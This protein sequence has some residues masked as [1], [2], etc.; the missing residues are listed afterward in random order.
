[1]RA[2]PAIT[3]LDLSGRGL[4]KLHLH[5]GAGGV[6]AFPSGD[7]I[8][9]SFTFKE[10]WVIWLPVHILEAVN[11]PIQEKLFLNY[12]QAC[13]TSK[14]WCDNSPSVS[15]FDLMKPSDLR[16]LFLVLE[17]DDILDISPG[18]SGR[19]HTVE[20]IRSRDNLYADL[21]SATI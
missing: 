3:E 10:S 19:I 1:M 4:K 16:M 11:L 9:Y 7:V 17:R 12:F 18:D 21:I 13:T 2:G 14:E 20:F 6:L 15:A 8:T 5:S